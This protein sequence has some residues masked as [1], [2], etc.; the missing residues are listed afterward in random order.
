MILKYVK[1]GSLYLLFYYDGDWYGEDK[2]KLR[3]GC[4]WY[5][6]LKEIVLE[7]EC[8]FLVEFEYY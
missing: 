4:I 6:D 7:N 5:G 3:F 2:V 1:E 8:V